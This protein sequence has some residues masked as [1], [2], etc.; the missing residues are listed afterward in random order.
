MII[1]YRYANGVSKR[2]YQYSHDTESL[3]GY[4][5]T[6]IE[7]H[8]LKDPEVLKKE[9]QI[10]EL[11]DQKEQLE[12]NVQFIDLEFKSKQ[13]TLNSIEE[14]LKQ[15]EDELKK[16]TIRHD[17]KQKKVSELV[18]EISQKDDEL[19]KGIKE[20]ELL[21]VKLGSIKERITES[22]KIHESLKVEIENTKVLLLA[23]EEEV[24]QI[25]IYIGLGVLALI[26]LLVGWR[27]RRQYRRGYY[28]QVPLE[29]EKLA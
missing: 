20:N 5:Q 18:N 15:T 23:K 3:F 11:V 28:R 7:Q 27:I 10:Q 6:L 22:E 24:F 17:E 19:K 16:V 9:Q 12:K 14:K 1:F 4:I 29:A 21:Q 13:A 8:P 26:L 25:R 2:E